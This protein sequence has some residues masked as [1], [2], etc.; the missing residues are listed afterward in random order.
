MMIKYY[1]TIDGRYEK[2]KSGKY[3]NNKGIQ[4]SL[5]YKDFEKDFEH[6]HGG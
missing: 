4:P 5:L 3:Q 1:H 2:Y 6:E